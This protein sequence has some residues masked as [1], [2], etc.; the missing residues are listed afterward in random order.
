MEKNMERLMEIAQ[1]EL[2][3]LPQTITLDLF[4]DDWSWGETGFSFVLYSYNKQ[5][6]SITEHD[7]YVFYYDEDEE[8]CGSAEEQLSYW[9]ETF[10]T[11]IGTQ[12]FY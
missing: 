1:K 3:K 10:F 7:S 8:F 12:D 2:E 4:A 9:L 5:T 11:H 6:H